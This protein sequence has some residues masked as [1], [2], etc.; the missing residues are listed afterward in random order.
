MMNCELQVKKIAT[1]YVKAIRKYGIFQ[2]EQ[3]TLV[4]L[5]KLS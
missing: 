3:I 5:F 2:Y 4:Y 1:L